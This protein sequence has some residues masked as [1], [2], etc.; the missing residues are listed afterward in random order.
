MIRA[1]LLLTM[2]L[3]ASSTYANL[4]FNDDFEGDW[5]GGRAVYEEYVYAPT[6]NEIYWNFDGGA[7]ASNSLSAWGGLA[8]DGG[9]FFFLQGT[10]SFSQQFYLEEDSFLLLDFLWASRKSKAQVQTVKVF[11]DDIEVTHFLANSSLWSSEQ[12]RIESFS[13]GLHTLEFRGVPLT[14]EDTAA[15]I[16]NVNLSIRDVNSPNKL[17]WLAL[18]LIGFS[19]YFRKKT[20]K[21]AFRYLL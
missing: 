15:F 13:K 6:G 2:S 16:D 4:L 12:Y 19:G 7:G 8:L 9:R 10:G 17:G 18:S 20:P 5:D 14:Q 11:I 3:F 1:T 21:I